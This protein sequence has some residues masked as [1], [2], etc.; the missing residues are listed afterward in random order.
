MSTA[1]VRLH[2][3]H[4]HHAREA[5]EGAHRPAFTQR[6]WH[7]TFDTDW[8][9]GST[10]VWDNHGVTIDDPE[11]VVLEPDPF[12]RLAYTWHTFTPELGATFD[13]TRSSPAR[14]ARSRARRSR[15]TSRTRVRSCC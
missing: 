9:V 10:M 13:S 6:Y 5:L 8:Q 14:S 2:H 1:D 3:L 15:S 4:P 12:P 11:Q 7:T